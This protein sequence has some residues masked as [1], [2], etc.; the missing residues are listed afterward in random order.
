MGNRDKR[1]GFRRHEEEKS[2]LT[3]RPM[4]GAFKDMKIGPTCL[5]CERT[6]DTRPG[7]SLS[8]WRGAKGAQR[9]GWCHTDCQEQAQSTYQKTEIVFMSGRIPNK[10]A[11]TT[12]I[13]ELRVPIYTEEELEEACRRGVRS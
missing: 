13:K 10:Q 1:G 5:K 11:V 9:Q 8:K 12:T 6:V 2:E 4:A 7:Q 3:S